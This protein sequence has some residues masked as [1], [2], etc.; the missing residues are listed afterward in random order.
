MSEGGDKTEAPTQKRRDDA[1]EKGDVLKSRDLGTALVVLAGISWMTFFGPELLAACREV[2]AA[3]FSFGRADVEDFQPWRPLIQ[4][5]WKLAPPLATLF[6]ITIGAA[7]ASQAGLGSLGFNAGLLAPKASRINPGSG[8]KRIIGMQGWIELGKS[9]LKVTLLGTIGAWMLWQTAHFSFGLASSNLPVALAGLGSTLTH[10]LM[11]MAMGLM[12]IAMVD[13][14][15]QIMQ[16]LRKLRMTKQE[17]KDEHKESDGN[18]EMKGHM[19]MKQ[20][21]LLSGGMTKALDQAHVVLTNP[22]H[23]AVALRYDRG[24]DEVPV[25]VAKGRGAMALAIREAA[26]ARALPILEYPALARAVYYTSREGQEVRDDLYMAIATVL[27]FVFGLNAEAGGTQP[28]I[29]VPTTAR[30]DENGVQP[31]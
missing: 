9:L 8:L 5:G 11:V 3:S 26:G 16:L 24:R 13:V 23:F 22:T 21:E 20:R 15:T 30:F 14:P 25:V 7:V 18:P 31:S 17:V 2:M 4:A 1:R 6:A 12:A 10:V 19:R 29:E 27:A 28:P